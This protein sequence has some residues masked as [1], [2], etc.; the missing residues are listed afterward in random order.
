M[1]DMVVEIQTARGY[2]KADLQLEPPQADVIQKVGKVLKP[3]QP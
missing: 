3:R 2:E 1:T